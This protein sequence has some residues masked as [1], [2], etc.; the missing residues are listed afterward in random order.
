MNN[1]QHRYA[2]S[3]LLTWH[4]KECMFTWLYLANLSLR[5]GAPV[6]ICEH[7]G[8]A[9][10]CTFMDEE[11]LEIGEDENKGERGKSSK[12]TCP[13]ANPTDRSAIKLSSVSPLRWLTMTP[14]PAAFESSAAWIDS[15]TVPIWLTCNQGMIRKAELSLPTQK[16]QAENAKSIFFRIS[17][18]K[19]Y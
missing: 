11:N 15:V 3:P 2:L 19:T 5:Q 4:S 10:V 7:D 16:M 9:S 6:L 14:H 17:I 12:L 1:M 8:E 13:L 18:W